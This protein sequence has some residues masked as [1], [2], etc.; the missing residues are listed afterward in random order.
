[1]RN[2]DDYRFL[3]LSDAMSALNQRVN[4]IGIVAE[5]GTPTR[6]KGTG[7]P[8][9]FVLIYLSVILFKVFDCWL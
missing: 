1:M 6:S 3:K 8:F 9:S 4:L 2:R 7:T 5:Y